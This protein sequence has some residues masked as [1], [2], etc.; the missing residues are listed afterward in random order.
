MSGK[1]IR[2]TTFKLPSKE[3]QQKMIGL[4]K[5]LSESARKVC[6]QRPSVGAHLCAA[7]RVN[8]PRNPP[9]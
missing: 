7:S 6:P 5:A 9:Y 3:S 2:I 1:V 8:D 4:Y